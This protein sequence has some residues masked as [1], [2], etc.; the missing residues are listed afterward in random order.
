M[1]T[2][3]EKMCEG[4]WFS[5]ALSLTLAGSLCC[6]PANPRA[7]ASPQGARTSQVGVPPANS[8]SGPPL[9]AENLEATSLE[10]TSPHAETDDGLDDDIA[11][12][13][14]SLSED[15]A[16]PH[17]AG[18][19]TKLKD[20]TAREPIVYRVSPQ[21]L[22]IE[23]DGLHFRP[24]AEAHRRPNGSYGVEIELRAEAFDG[25]NYWIQEPAEGPLSIAGSVVSPN[26]RK[27]R[28]GDRRQGGE[29]QL[30]IGGE[31]VVFRQTWPGKGQPRL[32]KGHTLTLEIGLWGT[33]EENVRERPVRRLFVVKLFAGKG[34]KPVISPPSLDW[35]N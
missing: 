29:P 17:S 6:S 31:T 23:V 35:G 13:A 27:S 21:G 14:E 10:A 1:P 25:R 26:G 2:L 18:E 3:G 32:L 22:T 4:D 30:V 34:A 5:V 11:A 9:A 28:F 12:I 15:S 24:T 8:A 33:R 7:S 16:S 19:N 20:A